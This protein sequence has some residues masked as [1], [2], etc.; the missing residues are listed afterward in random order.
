MKI[1]AFTKSYGARRVLSLPPIEL[2]DGKI[3]VLIGPN[4]SGKSTLARVLAG[5]E[6]ADERDFAPPAVSVGY[7]PQK[8]WAFR[9]STEKNVLLGGPD[10]AR[11]AELM[12]AMGIDAL[13]RRNAKKLSG[14]ET[15]RMALCRILMGEHELLILDEPTASMDMAS[16]LEAERLIRAACVERGSTV[17]LI[18]HSLA[19]ARRL[20]EYALF[21]SRGE[22]VEQGEAAQLLRSPREEETRRFLDFYG[23]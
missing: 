16:T 13:A 12:R 11:A 7:M 2:P 22:L 8:S 1:A 4:G 19:Q 15:A 6:R 21:L 14:G 23:A 18:S 3:S 10:T 5:V 20:A 17:L 9:M